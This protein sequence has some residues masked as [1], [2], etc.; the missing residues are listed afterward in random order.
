MNVYSEMPVYVSHKRVHALQ[1]RGVNG[2]LLQFD[3]GFSAI[4][5][6]PEMFVRYTPV[7][8]DYLVVYEDGYRSISPQ[9]AFESG[10]TRDKL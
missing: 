10:Y 2:F 3:E 9:A 6:E 7:P 4:E 1:I 5:V 8:G